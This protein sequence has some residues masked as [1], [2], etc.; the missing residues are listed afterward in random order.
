MTE[1]EGDNIPN[2]DKTVYIQ[3]DDQT[4]ISDTDDGD[5]LHVCRKCNKIFKSLEEYLEHKV[6][7]EN[8]RISQTRSK[9]DRRM[10]L[11]QLVQKQKRKDKKEKVEVSEKNEVQIIA[12]Q[13]GIDSAKSAAFV[14]IGCDLSLDKSPVKLEGVTEVKQENALDE[15]LPKKRGR[16]KKSVVLEAP[17]VKDVVEVLYPCTQCDKKFRREATLRWHIKYEHRDDKEN[18][19]DS[20]G[21]YLEEV[22]AE[23]DGDFKIDIKGEE[24]E[25]IHFT[26]DDGKNPQEIHVIIEQPGDVSKL[27]GAEE[28]DGGVSNLPCKQSAVRPR[29]LDRPFPCEICGRCFKEITVLKAHGVVHSNERKYVCTADNCPYGFKTKG[30]LVRHMRRHTGERPFTCESCGRAFSE[31]GALSRHMKSRRNCAQTP[32]SAYP[33]YMKNWTYHPNIPAVIDPSQR[34]VFQGRSTLQHPVNLTEAE[35][36]GG[37][38]HYLITGSTEGSV[39][40]AEIITRHASVVEAVT[41]RGPDLEIVTTVTAQQGFSEHTHIP[42]STQEHGVAL[43]SPQDVDSLDSKHN[44]EAQ[45]LRPTQCRVCRKDLKTIEGLE[46]HLRSHLADQPARCVLCHFLSHDREELRQHNLSMHSDSLNDIEASVLAMEEEEGGLKGESFQDKKAATRDALIAVREL[47][48]LKKQNTSVKEEKSC[49]TASGT[50]QC[51]V[52]S[53]YFRGNGYL[54]QHMRTHIGDRPYQ[55]SICSRSFTSRDILKKHMFVHKEQRD[56][57]CGECGKLFKRLAHVQQHFRIHSQERTYR[58][59]VCDKPFKTQNSLTVHMRTHSGVNPYRCHVCNKHFRER[60]S[61]QRHMRLHTGE[62]PYKCP[63]CKRAFAEHGTLS[64]HLKAKVPC[65]TNHISADMDH[66]LCSSSTMLTQFSTVV[67]NT[68]QYIQAADTSTQYIQQVGD[69]QQLMLPSVQE[70]NEGYVVLDTTDKHS[71]GMIENVEVITEEE[72][73]QTERPDYYDGQETETLQIVDSDTGESVIIMA[74]KSIVDLIREQQL[75]FESGETGSSLQK[76]KDILHAAGNVTSVFK[77]DFSVELESQEVDSGAEQQETVIE[78]LDAE[79]PEQD[80]NTSQRQTGCT[81]STA[82]AQ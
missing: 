61:L 75:L 69:S 54:L 3:Q 74:D 27:H 76:I 31:S 48:N 59:S 50:P 12:Q 34:D 79:M 71:E 67:A 36:T 47:Y 4:L 64:R 17:T 18:G 14:I 9:L 51:M 70:V 6:K 29:E 60:G 26:L 32:D 78:M 66:S 1:P 73:P 77:D 52:C 82:A 15:Q 19:E 44:V 37:E 38:I 80:S 53:R 43:E 20:E 21:E 72:L 57:K 23:N 25:T 62:K 8:Y 55:C 5:D 35:E 11:P 30:G 58:C 56:F 22:S 24:G 33:R 16:K 2:V 63:L 42:D 49:P 65:S 46:I 28:Q 45:S 7:Y 39:V 13:E 40:T 81:T 41:T 68:Q 10:V